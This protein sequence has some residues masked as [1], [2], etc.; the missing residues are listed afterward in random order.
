MESVFSLMLR[1]VIMI[2]IGVILKKANIITKELQKGISDV[3][4]KAILPLSIISST[5]AAFSKDTF[6]GITATCI[7]AGGYYILSLAGITLLSKRL[8]VS[9]E[10]RK[11]FITMCVFAN[12][13]FIGF[14]VAEEVF[15]TSAMLYAVLYNLFYQI[16]FFTYGI[17]ILD[18]ESGMNIMKVFQTPVTIASMLSIIKFIFQI[19][20]PEPVQAAFTS[21]GNMTVPLSMIIIGC[22]IV[23]M[24]CSEIVK[25]FYSYLV[26]LFRLIIFPVIAFGI[27]KVIGDSSMTAKLCILLTALPSGSLNVIVAEQKNCEPEFA[28]R[29]VV[30][31][32]IFMLI[33]LPFI[34]G[35]LK[36]L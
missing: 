28:A 26:S 22:T 8:S 18:K 6:Q 3:L 25:D 10:K 13:G 23:E 32:M 24:K 11:V 31:N 20:F 33:T 19:H 27:F 21:V 7:F 2:S 14:P 15:G 9:V 16:F 35:L 29:T 1:I 30:Q 34:I 4:L 5:E 12:T 36:F 17:Q